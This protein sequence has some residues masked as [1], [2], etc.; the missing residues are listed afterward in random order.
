MQTCHEN[1]DAKIENSNCILSSVFWN[2][3]Q[4]HLKV[5]RIITFKKEVGK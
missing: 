1:Y 3:L 4:P 5:I 2:T